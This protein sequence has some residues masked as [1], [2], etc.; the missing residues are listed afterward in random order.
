MDN[1]T[2]FMEKVKK[3]EAR[4]HWALALVYIGLFGA[5]VSFMPVR[6]EKSIYIF[7]FLGFYL[8]ISIGWGLIYATRVKLKE[9]IEEVEPGGNP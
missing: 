3:T 9:Y 5:L 8:L 1:N 4:L 6:K 7:V 2:G